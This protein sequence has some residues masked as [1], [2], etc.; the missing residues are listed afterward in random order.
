MTTLKKFFLA[1]CFALFM[2]VGLKIAPAAAVPDRCDRG[3]E[4][5]MDAADDPIDEL[6]C[7]NAW[8]ACKL[9]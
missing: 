8:L 6:N 1:M 3:Y 7:L 5:C 2:V 9:Y 4:S